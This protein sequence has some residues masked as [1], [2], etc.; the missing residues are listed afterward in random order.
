MSYSSNKGISPVIATLLLVV[1]AISAAYASWIWY[2]SLKNEVSTGLEGKVNGD[3][4]R[5]FA[6]LR[7]ESATTV[8][9]KLKN[10]GTVTLY[11]IKVYEDG[12]LKAT[13]PRLE[14]EKTITNYISLTAGKT[15]YAIAKYADDKL[16]ITQAPIQKVGAQVNTILGSG[17]STGLS[18]NTSPLP[19]TSSLTEVN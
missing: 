13:Y 6:G 5:L 10:T 16:I 15:L 19:I 11:D 4:S 18:V 2:E 17:D 8:G 3:V 12:A 9:Y 7:I 1:I 14:P